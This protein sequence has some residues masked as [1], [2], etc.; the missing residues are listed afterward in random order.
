MRWLYAVFNLVIVTG[1]LVVTLVW[2][3]DF[4][5]HWRAL[6]LS[7]FMV[8]LTWIVLDAA[9]HA[10]GWWSY[11]REFIV[12]PRLIG[13]PLEELAFFFTVPFACMVVWHALESRYKGGLPAA[14]SHWLLGAIT[15]A[16][17]VLAAVFVDRQRT[18]IDAGIT[19]LTA[20]ALWGTPLVR[21]KAWWYWN[22]VVILLFIVCNS[23]LTAAPVVVYDE[24][25]MT[26]W[27]IGTIPFEDFLYNF[28]LLNLVLLV[29]VR[30]RKLTDTQ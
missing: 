23:I 11:N 3:R 27:R 8:S 16:C 25:V 13:L 24:S 28:S 1:P 15:T 7:F 12:G 4:W 2:F 18:L 19:V 17:L 14:A 5:R 22:G 9:S 6:L 30:S 21:Q 20:A 10:S 26:G 29:Y